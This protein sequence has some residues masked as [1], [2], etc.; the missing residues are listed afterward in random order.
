MDW[1]GLL[2]NLFAIFAGLAIY[3]GVGNTKWG[4]E[5]SQYQYA[6]ML[7]AILAACL[8]GGALRVLVGKVL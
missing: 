4:K 6:I 3:I 7:V 2:I 8:I 5:H 1:T